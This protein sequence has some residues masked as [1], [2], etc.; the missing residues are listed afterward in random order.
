M[1]INVIIIQ[2]GMISWWVEDLRVP[3]F[4]TRCEDAQWKARQ[5]GLVI[6]DAWLVAFAS[7]SPL[8]EKNFPGE[9]PKFEGL[10]RLDRTWEKWK[11]HCQDAQEAL[12]RVIRHYNP[13]ADSFGSANA[14]A[15]IHRISHNGDTVQPVASRI[16]AQVPPPGAIPEE[17]FINSFSRIMD[18]MASAATSDKAVL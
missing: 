15:N 6:S 9:R 10:P 17:E 2:Q 16:R 1:A 12:E 11:S 18:N 14:A 8:T 5:A 3:E 7:R 13:S 4:I